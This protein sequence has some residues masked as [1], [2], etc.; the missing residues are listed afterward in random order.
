MVVCREAC[1]RGKNSTEVCPDIVTHP[2]A[3]IKLNIDGIVTSYHG[4][5]CSSITVDKLLLSALLRTDIA[6]FQKLITQSFVQPNSLLM[7]RAQAKASEPAE[8]E[9]RYKDKQGEC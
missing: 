8:A 1:D 7:T 5:Y 3:S 9:E 6:E 4:G 2:L